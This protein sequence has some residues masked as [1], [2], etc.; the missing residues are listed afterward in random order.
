M[1]GPI[2]KVA[3]GQAWFHFAGHTDFLKERTGADDVVM[4]LVGGGLRVGLVTHHV[5]LA[6]VPD[7]LVLVETD[8]PYLTPVPARGRPNASYLMPYTV[9]FMAAERGFD[10]ERMCRL[11]WDNARRVFGEW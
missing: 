2:S 7:E 10:E 1:T 4:M 11:L 9:R 8:A 5:A 6:Q 3:I